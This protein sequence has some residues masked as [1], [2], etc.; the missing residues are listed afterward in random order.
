MD[1][2][3]ITLSNY[4]R[5]KVVENKSRG[6]VLNGHH[7]SFYQYIIDRNNGSPTNSSINKTYNSLIYGG[8]L[9]YKNG[10]YG[11]NDWAKLQTVLRPADIRKMVAD[12]QVF[13][14]FACQVIQTKGGDISS[15]KHI[16]KQMVVPSICNEDYEID[17]YWYSRNWRKINQNAPEQFPAFGYNANAPI[18]IYVGS[19]YT[20]GDVYFATPDYLAGM[21]Y[22]E[23][24]EELA[25]LNINSIK[26]GLSAGYIINVPNGKSLTPQEK[27]DFERQVRNRLTRTPNASQFILS[28]NGADVEITVTPLPQNSAIHKQW[29]WLSGEAK[30][31]IMTAHRVI[32]PSIIGLSTSS[33]FSSVAEEMDM[34]ERQMVK[35][36]IQPKKDFMTESFE[37]I[38]SQFGMN[39]DL[40]FKPLTEDELKE[41]SEENNT[42]IGLKKKD[43]IDEFIEMGE[44]SLDGYVPIDVRRCDEVTLTEAVLDDYLLEMTKS[45]KATPEKKSKQDTSLFAVRYRYAGS[46][47]QSN[48]REFC[49]KVLSA[50]RFY[51]IEDLDKQSTANSKFAP[52][53]DTSYNIFLYKGGVNCKHWFERVIFLKENN[54]RITVTK[55]VKMILELEPSERADAKWQTNPKQVAQI[56]EQQNNYWSLTPNYRDSGVTPQRLAKDVEVEFESYNDYPESAKNNAQKVLDWR[57]KYGTEVKGMTR[58]GWVRANQ[59]AKGRNIS[60]STIARMSAFQRH[61]KNSEVSAENKSTPWKDKGYVAW[62]GWGGTSGIN[63]AS[64]KLKQID[65]K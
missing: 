8:G 36:V 60:R 27:D 47:S 61:K 23:F 33:G 65:K 45:P 51:R 9:T 6:Y 3:L 13:G 44:E 25:N 21:P 15:I 41:S 20:V 48:Q 35:R 24:E 43:S 17:S 7:N 62:L 52:S 14:E 10:I 54:K 19:P 29:D 4:V 37:H 40:M 63:W 57:E 1:I 5:P 30:N 22:C 26:N 38:I 50:R 46:P 42:D 56:A 34:A 28:F 18:S 12:F 53:G 39:L 55:A 2:K 11:V 49:T 31:Q 64:K 16:P 59:L 32:S 58:V